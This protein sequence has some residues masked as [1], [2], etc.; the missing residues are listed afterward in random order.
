MPDLDDVVRASA[1][2]LT[3]REARGPVLAGLSGGADSQGLLHLLQRW[4]AAAG[5]QLHAIHVDH[6]LRPDSAA[7]AAHV[8][9]LCEEWRVPLVVERVAID[10][11]G[12][13]RLGGVEQAARRERYR[14]FATVA[15]TL[16]VTVLALG[17]QRDDQAET[18][19]L[20][21]L[22]GAGLPGLRGMAVVARSDT[23]L[24]EFAP[25]PASRPALWR[26][27]LEVSRDEIEAYCRRHGL[28]PLLDPTND[29]LAL[30]RNAVRHAILPALEAR[31]PQARASLAR[32]ARLLA[33]EDAAL[34]VVVDARWARL[35]KWRDGVATLDRAGFRA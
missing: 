9:A 25:Y 17:H 1:S 8:A 2:A 13:G 34:Q 10:Q 26:P 14:A 29:D 31:F 20:H 23:A 33:D 15:A 35:G 5:A 19:L 7:D 4:A 3:A 24:D 18:V 6:G 27:L 32:T 12:A 16:G 11:G 30:R 28:R 21:L 22:R